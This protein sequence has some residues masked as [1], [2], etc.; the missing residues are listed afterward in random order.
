MHNQF[1]SN[2]EENNILTNSHHGF[3]PKDSTIT[4]LLELTNTW[5]NIDIGQLKV[6]V[7]LCGVV[8]GKQYSAVCVT[9]EN[10]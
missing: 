2:L 6:T 5:Y 3:R 8:R 7:H 1:Y 4:A 10:I 9:M